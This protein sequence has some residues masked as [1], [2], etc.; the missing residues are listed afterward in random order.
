M[1]V[2]RSAGVIFF[3]E[4]KGNRRYLI[5]HST[6]SSDYPDFWDF[7]KGV[8]EGNEVGVDAALREAKEETGIVDFR[9][10][11]GFKYTARYFRKNRGGTGVI[12]KFVTLF[13]ARAKSDTVTLSWEHE[14]YEWLPYKEACERLTNK[15]MKKAL[16]AAEIFLKQNG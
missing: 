1:P 14:R 16:E 10:V 6:P 8:L 5:L 3:N 12:P 15:E 7:S 4:I 2:E 9:I 13:L 11:D